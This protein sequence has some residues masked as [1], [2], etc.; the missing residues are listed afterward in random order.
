MKHHKEITDST[1]FSLFGDK[2]LVLAIFAF[3]MPFLGSFLLIRGVHWLLGS[4]V[5]IVWTVINGWILWRWHRCEYLR[6]IISLP[7]TLLGIAAA[8]L[9]VWGT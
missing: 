8:A 6:L 5:L 4:A 7:C 3:L 9:F 1:W 2:L